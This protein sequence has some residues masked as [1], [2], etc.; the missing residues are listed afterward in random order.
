[1]HVIHISEAGTARQRWKKAHQLSRMART[2]PSLG[3]RATKA[4]QKATGGKWSAKRGMRKQA[5]GDL[6]AAS[7][8]RKSGMKGHAKH[9]LA[10][11][12]AGRKAS[13][14]AGFKLPESFVV[15][16]NFSLLGE[17][18]QSTDPNR[19]WSKKTR[20]KVASLAR[21]LRQVKTKSL[22]GKEKNRT[23]RAHLRT[24]RN[25][26]RS[27][28]PGG[29]QRP[30]PWES[31]MESLLLREAGQSKDPDWAERRRHQLHRY[32]KLIQKHVVP[33]A[34]KKGQVP[35]PG[36]SS[37]AQKRAIRVHSVVTKSAAA[38]SARGTK[39]GAGGQIKHDPKT[40]AGLVKSYR[41]KKMA[42][43]KAGSRYWKERV[44]HIPVLVLPGLYEGRASRLLGVHRMMKKKATEYHQS[45]TARKTDR[46]GKSARGAK[47][48]AIRG[49]AV[50]SRWLTKG[51]TRRSSQRKSDTKMS[52]LLRKH[53]LEKTGR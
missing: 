18:G 3:A 10:S 43:G 21:E 13:V 15:I 41:K 6:R 28:L 22:T 45:Q 31:A 2:K 38:W 29:K 8:Y 36:A 46:G 9:W 26:E 53:K 32:G 52:Q 40:M 47:L 11:A 33:G 7:M 48:K 16:P 19:K 5:L 20:G 12:R 51:K 27:I 39:G 1:M 42:G 24:V 37:K 50:L 49:A 14:K 30:M 34:T 35:D 4:M 25:R 17:A 23:V 44:N